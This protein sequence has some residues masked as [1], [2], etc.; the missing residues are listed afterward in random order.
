MRPLGQPREHVGAAIPHPAGREPDE[1]RAISATAADFEPLI[2]NPQ[3]FGGLWGFQQLV[4]VVIGAGF[5]D[6]VGSPI[7]VMSDWNWRYGGEQHY[8]LPIRFVWAGLLRIRFTDYRAH[9]TMVFS[10]RFSGRPAA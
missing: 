4:A 1:L 3:P 8:D 2:A 10:L 9:K 6:F 5:G 7:E